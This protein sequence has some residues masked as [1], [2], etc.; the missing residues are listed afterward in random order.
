MLMFC[1]SSIPAGKHGIVTAH[2]AFC[3]SAKLS[4]APRICQV[5]GCPYL[6]SLPK[7]GG[8]SWPDYIFYYQPY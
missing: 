2:H 3:N 7:G 5:L 6:S 8:R 4:S 1:W